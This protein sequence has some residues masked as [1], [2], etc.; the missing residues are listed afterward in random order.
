MTPIRRIEDRENTGDDGDVVAKNRRVADA[1][2]LRAH[3]H[4]S[5]RGRRGLE[6]DSEEH[7]VLN[8]GSSP[9]YATRQLADRRCARRPREPS[10]PADRHWFQERASCPRTR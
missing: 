1:F 8:R 9:P 3:E 2:R 10:A 7:H 4:E 5:R 6:A